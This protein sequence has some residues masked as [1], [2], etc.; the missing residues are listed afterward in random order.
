[1]TRPFWKMHG[2]GND[3]AVFDARERP[4]MPGPET[5]RRLADRRT[6]IGF[7]Q[8]L[9]IGPGCSGA[10]IAMRIWN[11]D[12][13][14]VAACG[15]GTRAVAALVGRPQLT[16]AT[17]AGTLSAVIEPSGQVTVDMGEP[18]LTWQAVPLAEPLD[19]DQL[20]SLAPLAGRP[21]VA[22]PAAVSIGN[23]H[24]TLFAG[25]LQEWDVAAVGR[26][27]QGHRMFPEGVNVGFA[28]VTG[29]DTLRL[30]VY[31][32]GAGLTLACGTGACAAAVNAARLGL[33]GRDVRLLLDG[34]ALRVQWGSDNRIRMTGPAAVA[35]TGTIAEE[36]LA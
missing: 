4:F 6:G 7:D 25:T 17:Q 8:L 23:P 24:V 26:A 13:E 9:V 30:R 29:P 27:I 22:A 21:L 36:A 3:F 14:E 2:L 15:N 1:M 33:T 5:V 35:F 31:E 32:R 18:G 19:T 11:S 16:I 20:D 12:G 34:G 28:A 10:D